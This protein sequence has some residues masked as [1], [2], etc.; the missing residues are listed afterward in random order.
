MAN[1][2]L[3]NISVDFNT[4]EIVSLYNG[5]YYNVPFISN[6]TTLKSEF[7]TYFNVTV[8]R[9]VVQLKE[10]QYGVGAE[11]RI[12]AVYQFENSDISQIVNLTTIVAEQPTFY[13]ALQATRVEIEAEITAQIG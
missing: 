9:A 3:D 7:E 6:L 8:E 2:D 12:V 11:A 1:L 10:A 5:V 13:A 4:D